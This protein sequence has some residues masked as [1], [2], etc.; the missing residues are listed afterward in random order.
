MRFLF[1]T[2]P[3]IN[4]P[5]TKQAYN[6]TEGGNITCTA[7]GYPVPDIVWLNNGSVVD[8]NRLV[9]IS[10]MATG[11]SNV[12]SMSVS[13][14]V[15]RDDGGVYTCV[16]NNFLGYDSS[17]VNITVQCKFCKVNTCCIVHTS[18]SYS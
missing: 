11:V 7:T 2:I 16:A 8:K 10:I 15:R 9:P 14:V 5:E 6:I 17:T 4:I 12:S 13:M 3:I 18:I 1:I